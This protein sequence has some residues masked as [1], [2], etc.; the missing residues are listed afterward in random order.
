MALKT[1]FFYMILAVQMLAMVCCDS[2]SPKNHEPIDAGDTYTHDFE[3][4]TERAILEKYWTN[5]I[6]V[7]GLDTLDDV[8]PFREY[9]FEI[10]HPT[11]NE[12][13]GVMINT[14]MIVKTETNQYMFKVAD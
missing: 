3:N 12:D 13:V 11:E 6:T 2:P 10:L 14:G 1:T 7:P 4:S 9:H 8:E 5:P